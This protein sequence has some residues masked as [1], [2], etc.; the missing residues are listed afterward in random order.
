MPKKLIFAALFLLVVAIWG[1][2]PWIITSSWLT[3]TFP[4]GN[5]QTRGTIGDSF[6]ALNTLFS[7][8]ALSALALSIYLQSAELKQLSVKEDQTAKLVASQAETLRLTALL[9]YYNNE[10]DRMERLSESVEAS[11]DDTRQRFWARHAQLRGDRDKI[12]ESLNALDIRI[13]GQE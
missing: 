6:G 2:Y 9:S 5:W 11:E 12:L 1:A 7:G 4:P 13:G 8:L 3:A 10:V